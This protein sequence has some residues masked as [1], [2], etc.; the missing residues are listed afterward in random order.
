MKKCGSSQSRVGPCVVGQGPGKVVFYDVASSLMARLVSLAMWRSA[1]AMTNVRA[2]VG[3]G[4]VQLLATDRYRA[5]HGRLPA[6]GA[7]TALITGKHF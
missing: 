4:S 2:E 3:G 7:G 5:S 1:A 6:T